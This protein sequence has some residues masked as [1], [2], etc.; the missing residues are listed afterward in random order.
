[1]LNPLPIPFVQSLEEVVQAQIIAEHEKS[2]LFCFLDEGLHFL[3]DLLV[4]AQDTVVTVLVSRRV[5]AAAVET[6]RTA[7]KLLRTTATWT[8]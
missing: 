2:L 6:M 5:V 8:D 4:Q 1:M 3:E 7:L